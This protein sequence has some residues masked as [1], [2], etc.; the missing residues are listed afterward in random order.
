MHN[1][2]EAPSGRE[3]R[4]MRLRELA[5]GSADQRRRI[6]R[7]CIPVVDD[8]GME[9]GLSPHFG[10]APYFALV[11][12]ESARAT[13]VECRGLMTQDAGVMEEAER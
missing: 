12:I 8:R 10:N 13:V 2:R 7:L 6:M 4:L 9:A 11:E 3:P 5:S 1:K